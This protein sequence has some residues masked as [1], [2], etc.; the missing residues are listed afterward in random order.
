MGKVHHDCLTSSPTSYKQLLANVEVGRPSRSSWSSWPWGKP[1]QDL[2]GRDRGEISSADF[3]EGRPSNREQGEKD[4]RGDKFGMVRQSRRAQSKCAASWPCQASQ[5]TG[6]MTAKAGLGL[7]GTAVPTETPDNG[8]GQ[9]RPASARSHP[10]I[11]LKFGVA[12]SPWG[13]FGFIL[14]GTRFAS[15]RRGI[16]VSSFFFSF[17]A[18]RTST[19]SHPPPATDPRSPSS[20]NLALPALRTESLPS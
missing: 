4:D 10:L 8:S 9:P 15:H 3:R 13:G 2:I 11:P 5:G 12:V 20:L 6:S 19:S 16:G 17:F 7:Q 14:C 1:L 18:N